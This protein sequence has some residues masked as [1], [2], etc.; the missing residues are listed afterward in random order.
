MKS[1]ARYRV[2]QF[3]K[4][5]QRPPDVDD[6]LLVKSILTPREVE[7]FT[8]LPF[9]DQNHSI[10]VYKRLISQGE[11]D[12][13]L[14][15][16]AL[17]HDIGK[18]KYPLRRWERVFTVLVSGLFPQQLERWGKGKPTGLRRALAVIQNHP[19][20]GAELAEA[21]GCNPNIVWLIRNHELVNLSS[22][23][24]EMNQ[25]LKKLQAADNIN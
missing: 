4:S 5:L 20:W 2:W 12:S 23:S 13:D 19:I 21:A 14:L 17:L 25:K 9:P 11:S 7:L 16:A 10:R 18:I 1:S 6:L 8:Q 15:K 3:W 22:S 24:P